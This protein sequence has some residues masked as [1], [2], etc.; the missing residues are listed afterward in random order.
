MV[1]SGEL[2]QQA[3][4]S[5]KGRW[6]QA[7]LLNLIP[8]LIAIALVMI[9]VLPIALLV[10]SMPD[11]AT[12][13]EEATNTSSGGS[14]TGLFSSI[15]TALFMSGISWTYLDILR[16]QRTKIEPF[17]DA[18]RG[19]SGMFFGGVI[20][21]ALLTTIFTSLWALLLVIPGIIKSYSY[22]Q[23]Y[24]IYYDIV[25]ETGEKPKVLDT[26]TASRKLM[27]GYKGKLFWL[28]LS[29]IG[30]HILA[31][32]TLGIG[33]LWLNPYISATKAA[34]YNQLPKNI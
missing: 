29:F 27:D 26:I 34:F 9:L 31:L 22:S 24:F 17:K 32:A 16:G 1:S 7:I 20:L 3:K 11:T 8:S 4:D 21:L 14:G 30:W 23:S 18:F 13:M 28:D 33:Y 25:T 6:G 12:M 15:I 5:L 10:A 19:F 2:K